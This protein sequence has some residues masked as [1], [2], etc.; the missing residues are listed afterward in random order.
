MHTELSQLISKPDYAHWTQSIDQQTR[1]SNAHWTQSSDQ[2]VR[3]EN[4]CVYI[5][6]EDKYEAQLN[7]IHL[8]QQYSC[9]TT[10]TVTLSIFLLDDLYCYSVDIPAGRPLLLLCRYSFWATFTVT[11]SIFLLDDLY[12]YSV[13]LP[14]GRHLLL[15]CRYVYYSHSSIYHV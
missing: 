2:Q 1:L 4:Y 3:Y 9:W 13:D 10:F 7:H 12:C 6:S 8:D 11:L 14:A 15:L 5:F